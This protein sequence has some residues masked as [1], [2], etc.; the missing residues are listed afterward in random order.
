MRQ[1]RDKGRKKKMLNSQVPPEELQT[2]QGFYSPF[3]SSCLSSL[4]HPSSFLQKKPF[5]LLHDSANYFLQVAQVCLT[6]RA[7][8]VAQLSTVSLK[9][10]FVE[11]EVA[12]ELFPSGKGL[13]PKTRNN[14]APDSSTL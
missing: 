7:T 2:V 5:S 12:D 13:S 3:H 10:I 4:F 14:V 1:T 6:S 9:N 8:S 11:P